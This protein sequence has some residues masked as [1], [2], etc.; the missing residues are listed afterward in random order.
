VLIVID[1][2][3]GGESTGIVVS[4]LVIREIGKIKHLKKEAPAVPGDR[5]CLSVR[6][7]SE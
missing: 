7:K 6:Y 2:I 5:R 3:G 1:R 4:P